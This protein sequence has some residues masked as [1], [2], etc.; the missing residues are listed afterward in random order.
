MTASDH[1]SSQ[2]SSLSELAK[3]GHVTDE[4]STWQRG[5][6][7][8]YA[9]ALRE[10]H[11]HL[12]YGALQEPGPEYSGYA[13][14]FAHDDTHAYDSAGKHPLPYT[15]IHGGLIQHLD[16]DP[17]DFDPPE[18]GDPGK[19]RAHIMRHGIGF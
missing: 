6:C 11:P 14:F 16:E 17:N 7:D 13:H 8:T 4:W 12:R 18:V 9:H 10:V 15:G 2:F 1:L 3:K 19:A 5:G